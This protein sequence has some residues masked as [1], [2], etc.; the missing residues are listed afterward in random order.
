M[1][2]GVIVGGVFF[3]GDEL[4]GMEKLPVRSGADF[5]D[6]RWFEVDE[7]RSGNVFTGSRLAEEGVE[8]V[9]T[10]SDCFVWWHLT[11]GL[12]AMFETVKFPTRIADLDTSLTNM[13]WDAF[14]LKL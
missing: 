14:T 7:Y 11:V 6:Y 13:Y 9:V 2:S 1:A 10:P 5:I 8:T 3:A 4:F 12:D